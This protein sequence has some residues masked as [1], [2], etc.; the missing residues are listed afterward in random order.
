LLGAVEALTDPVPHI[1]VR[2]IYDQTLAAVRAKDD[3]AVAAAFAE[4]H[5]MS[6]E[7]AITYA[8]EDIEQF[9]FTGVT[10]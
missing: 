7:Q 8:L 9:T 2:A 1:V 5:A 4:G 6:P 3:Q 10:V